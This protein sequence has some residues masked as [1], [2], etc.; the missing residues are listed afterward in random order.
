VPS[1]AKARVFLGKIHDTW[2]ERQKALTFYRRS[3]EIEKARGDK[4]G[5]A[6]TGVTPQ[7]TVFNKSSV[8]Y[9]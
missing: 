9:S 2:G 3:S 6:A 7:S 4:T 5:K 8:S 1:L